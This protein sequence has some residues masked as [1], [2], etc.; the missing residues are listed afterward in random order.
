MSNILTKEERSALLKNEFGFPWEHLDQVILKTEAAI[1]N[2]LATNSHQQIDRGVVV[3]FAVDRWI[4]EVS[5]RPLVNKNRRT[6]DDTWRQVIR[7]FGGDPDSLIGPDHDSL[8]AAE[9]ASDDTR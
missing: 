2:K 1:L 4:E 3:S 9:R 5:S 7:R 8:V 6:L